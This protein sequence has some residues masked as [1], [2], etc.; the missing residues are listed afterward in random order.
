MIL[1]VGID[2]VSISRIEK[3]HRR[4][5]ARFA[6]RI[7][8][9]SEI[10]E[11]SA[12]TN[13]GVFLAKRFATKEAAVKALGTGEREGVLLKDFWLTHDRLGKP[14]LQVAGRAKHYCENQGVNRQHVSLSDERDQVIAFVVLES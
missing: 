1:G 12:H 5:G 3:V 4:F 7:L 11:Y 10:D 9:D 13:K 8:S 6:R 14:L 2:L